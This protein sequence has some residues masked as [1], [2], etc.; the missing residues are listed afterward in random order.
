MGYK[1]WKASINDF[2]SGGNISGSINGYQKKKIF[3]WFLDTRELT[4]DILQK[5]VT[6]A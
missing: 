3:M 4:Y 2:S 5:K 6:R 1:P